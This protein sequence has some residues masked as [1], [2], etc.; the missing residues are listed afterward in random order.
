MDIKDIFPYQIFRV[1]GTTFLNA[2]RNAEIKISM[3]NPGGSHHFIRIY[4]KPL[5]YAMFF[6]TISR[7]IRLID[8][9]RESRRMD[10]TVQ[11]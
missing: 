2:N 5:E 1:L 8:T 4:S 6:F 11:I 10:L 3:S 7:M 9:E